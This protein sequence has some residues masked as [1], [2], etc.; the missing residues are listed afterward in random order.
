MFLQDDGGLR[1][2]IS[3]A[4]EVGGGGV[5]F[6]NC[7]S[8]VRGK[9]CEKSAQPRSHRPASTLQ[10]S[11]SSWL[12]L[13][14]TQLAVASVYKKL[15]ACYWTGGLCFSYLYSWTHSHKN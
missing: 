7:S 2:G 12:V 4:G 1:P 15:L 6:P 3:G 8:R 13:M 11:L 9:W 5:Q 10:T 14:V